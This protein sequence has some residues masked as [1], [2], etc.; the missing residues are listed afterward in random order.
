MAYILIEDFKAGIDRRRPMSAAHQGTLYELINAHI[1]PG[2]DIE[3]RKAF[4]PFAELPAGT[5]GLHAAPSGLMVFGSGEEPADMPP[6][7][8][9]RQLPPTSPSTALT[10]LLDAENFGDGEYAIGQFSNGTVAHYY[11]GARVEAWDTIM[12]EANSIHGVATILARRA[13]DGGSFALAASKDQYGATLL[14]VTGHQPETAFTYAL[15]RLPE[16]GVPY[17]YPATVVPS[18]NPGAYATGVGDLPSPVGGMERLIEVHWRSDTGEVMR[19]LY[20]QDTALP[21]TLADRIQ[22]ATNI[23]GA[24]NSLS[25]MPITAEAGPSGEL[26]LTTKTMTAAYNG[27]RVTARVSGR[28]PIF[29]TPFVD[30]VLI[31]SLSGGRATTDAGL[32]YVVTFQMGGLFDPRAT[33]RL[34]LESEVYEVPPG[35]YGA[36]KVALTHNGK[37]YSAARS[38]LFFSGFD[39]TTSQPDPTRWHE[40][41]DT[42][43]AGFIDMTMQSGGVESLIALGIYQDL[44]A[45]FSARSTYLWRM[46]ADPLLNQ[47][48]QALGNIGT[49]APGSVVPYGDHDLFFLSNTGVRSLRARDS[50]NT[51]SSV[52]IGT[53]IDKVIR[54]HLVTLPEGAAERATAAIDPESGRYWLALGDRI[55]VFSHYPLYRIAAWSI[56]QAPA[57]VD[58]IATL[59]GRLYLRCGD[60]IYLYGGQSNEEYDASTVIVQLPFLDNEKP[61]T[62]KSVTGFDVDCDGVWD[63]EML[64]NPKDLSHVVPVAN[65]I[66]EMTYSSGNIGVSFEATHFAP[67]LTCESNG[68]ARLSSIAVHIVKTKEE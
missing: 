55:Y 22:L 68:Y 29:N 16:Q 59:D 35:R 1:T 46:N 53:P 24:I 41:P 52:D 62:S 36:G 2:G 10:R 61:A 40:T 23:A 12:S 56:Y 66:A 47:S 27:W 13:S 60:T 28:D 49:I 18:P 45:V 43:G 67:R 51:A 34:E 37:V 33:Y 20:N 5:H 8:R 15:R 26:L 9:Y 25:N 63:A 21:S 44:L 17:D 30:D 39:K 14:Q 58:A 31:A 42:I 65:G 48:V 57:A 54:E 6:K 11:K 3:K 50:S 4:V 32:P 7:V 64:V 38:L 19:I